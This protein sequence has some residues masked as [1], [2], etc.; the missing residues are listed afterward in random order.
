MET[1]SLSAFH[2]TG[3][4]CLFFPVTESEIHD[5]IL[6]A[7]DVDAHCLVYKRYLKD[8]DTFALRDKIASRFIDTKQTDKVFNLY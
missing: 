1:S 8:L 4:Y 3:L 5:G 7:A 6:K 2:I